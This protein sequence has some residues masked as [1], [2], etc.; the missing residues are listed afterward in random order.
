MCCRG[1]KRAEVLQRGAAIGLA[2]AHHTPRQVR[3]HRGDPGKDGG[4]RH[5]PT[6]WVDY[7]EDRAA[8]PIEADP[9]IARLEC[10]GDQAVFAVELLQHVIEEA[11]RQRELVE[12]PALYPD[13]DGRRQRLSETSAQVDPSLQYENLRH[14][15]RAQQR[16]Q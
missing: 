13:M 1:H 15:R 10:T 12:E 8:Q 4:G 14:R 16:R 2:V 3:R 5:H 6:R 7:G 9:A 11:L